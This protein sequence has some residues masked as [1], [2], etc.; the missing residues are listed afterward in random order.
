MCVC[1][2][3]CVCDAY[4]MHIGL[5]LVDA[6]RLLGKEE[7]GEREKPAS[8]RKRERKREKER[9]RERVLVSER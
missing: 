9:E 1:V 4:Y 2:C 8:E 5:F 3:V 7:V 6:G